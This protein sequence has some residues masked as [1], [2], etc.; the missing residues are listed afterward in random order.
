MVYNKVVHLDP[1]QDIT[2]VFYFLYFVLYYSVF[3]S[4]Y[5][6]AIEHNT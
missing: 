5:F 3:T 6:S 1:Y 2:F 4:I